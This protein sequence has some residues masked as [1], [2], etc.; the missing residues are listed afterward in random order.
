MVPCY[1]R[2]NLTVRISL[3]LIYNL[4]SNPSDPLRMRYK[5][6]VPPEV[7][8]QSQGRADGWSC[9]GAWVPR[10]RPQA[11]GIA[12]PP[13]QAAHPMDVG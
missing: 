13:H 3:T 6:L 2:E 12:S 7:V 11:G 8:G 9:W 4:L 5:Y 1:F 10:R